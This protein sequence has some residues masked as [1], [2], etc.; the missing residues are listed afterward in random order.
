[1]KQFPQ[2]E[3][4]LVL[5]TDFSN[6][7]AW[8][9]IQVAIQRPV[10]IFRFRANIEFLDNLEYS[11]ITK[12]QLLSLLPRNY[13]HSLIIIADRFAVTQPEYPLLIVDLVERSGREFRAV[14][15]AV[16]SIENNLSLA[17]MDFEEFAEAVDKDGVFRGFSRGA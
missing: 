1:M 17:N 5:R 15:S 3:N 13:D 8:E 16:Q 11:G 7:A 6:Q 10:G 12:E 9:T 14:P 2:T 4:P